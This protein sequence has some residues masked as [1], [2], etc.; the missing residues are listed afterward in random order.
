[1]KKYI[2]ILA[3]MMVKVSCFGQTVEP[4][5]LKLTIYPSSGGEIGYV[6]EVK[7]RLLKVISKELTS[8][9]GKIVLGNTKDIKERKLSNHQLSKI[10]RHLFEL[11]NLEKKYDD[12]VDLI[13]DA[14]VFD[15]LINNKKSVKVNSQILDE[16]SNLKKTRKLI[17]CLRK[18]SPIEIDLRDFS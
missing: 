12:D 4:V 13:L 9:D 2:L 14:W 11:E 18:L 17:K 6:I 5:N 3:L 1:M 16:S 10:K 7:D 15:F 8:E